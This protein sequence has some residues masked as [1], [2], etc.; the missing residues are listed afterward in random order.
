MK[1][2]GWLPRPSR[3]RTERWKME[4]F[5]LTFYMMFPVIMFWV[6]NQPAFFEGWMDEH[7]K[8]AFPPI[9]EKSKLKIE[10]L[11]KVQDAADKK[12]ADKMFAELAKS[13]SDS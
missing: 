11:K 5:K 2:L 7:R 4:A 9:D 13:D 10:M 6:H 3:L 8:F 12:R 1:W